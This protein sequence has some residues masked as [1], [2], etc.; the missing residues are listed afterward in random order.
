MPIVQVEFLWRRKCVC[1]LRLG[2]SFFSK[3]MGLP[4]RAG[5]DAT[6]FNPANI[7]REYKESSNTSLLECGLVASFYCG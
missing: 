6:E 3:A 5:R 4:M 7:S 2:V 1:L